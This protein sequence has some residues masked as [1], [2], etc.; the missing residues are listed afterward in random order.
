[1]LG[2]QFIIF[3]MSANPNPKETIF[4]GGGNGSVM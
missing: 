2:K 1:M 4:N 3:G